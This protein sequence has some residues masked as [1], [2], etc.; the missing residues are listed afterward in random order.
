MINFNPVIYEVGEGDRTVTVRLIADKDFQ[1]PFIV[2]V[3]TTDGS[4]TG[5]YI[6]YIY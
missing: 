2:P 5:Q 3:N 1:Y 6:Q 4:A